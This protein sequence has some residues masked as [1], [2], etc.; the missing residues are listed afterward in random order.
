MSIGTTVRRQESAVAKSTPTRPVAAVVPADVRAKPAANREVANDDK[1]WSV[2]PLLMI[3][4]AFVVLFGL[5]AIL[6]AG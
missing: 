3:S 4:V 2:D 6:S 1:T 5:L